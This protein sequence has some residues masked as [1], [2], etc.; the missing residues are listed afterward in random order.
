[1]PTTPISRFRTAA[2][3]AQADHVVEKLE[4]R[5]VRKK[6]LEALKKAPA[7]EQVKILREV[8]NTFR[9]L[10]NEAANQVTKNYLGRVEK[11]MDTRITHQLAGESLSK[12]L[13]SHQS[14]LS[15]AL[16]NVDLTQPFE[17]GASMNGGVWLR[18]P[19]KAGDSSKT[20]D[21]VEKL[22]KTAPELK[23]FPELW[24]I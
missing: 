3:A 13:R 14:S 2:T 6:A 15:P 20:I 19:T 22:F 21:A 7:N 4:G 16:K 24:I 23:N 11:E 10:K 17:V 12:Y 8:R 18:L 5:D 1:M 9:K